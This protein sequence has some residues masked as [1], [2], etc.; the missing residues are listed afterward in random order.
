MELNMMIGI[1]YNKFNPFRVDMK[2]YNI[3]VDCTYGN[4][5]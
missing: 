3:H 1:C 2:D 4:C 5:C